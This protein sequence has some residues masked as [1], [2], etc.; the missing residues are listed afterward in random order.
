ME[1][2]NLYQEAD[3]AYDDYTNLFIQ[4]GGR[5]DY[6]KTVAHLGCNSNDGRTFILIADTTGQKITEYAKAITAARTYFQSNDDIPAPVNPVFAVG[7]SIMRHNLTHTR[8]DVT[9][10]NQKY[11]YV[12]TTNNEEISITDLGE[13]GWNLV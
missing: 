12:A 10:V 3:K 6:Q 11:G 1:K 8:C 5:R 13:E 4:Y 2:H 9:E 7:D